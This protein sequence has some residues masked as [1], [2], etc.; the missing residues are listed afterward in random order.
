MTFFFRMVSVFTEKP[1]SQ[2][3]LSLNLVSLKASG[4]SVKN[5]EVGQSFFLFYSYDDLSHEK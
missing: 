3:S 2:S 1:A 5:R 4:L